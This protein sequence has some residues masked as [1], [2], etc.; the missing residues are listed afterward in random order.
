MHRNHHNVTKFLSDEKTRGAINTNFFKRLDHMN[1]QLYEVELAM[2]EIEHRKPIIVGFFIVQYAKLRMLE[3][4]Y[5]FFERLF[6]VNNFEDI[7][8]D[9]DSLYLA[10]PEKY[11]CNCIQEES[12]GEWELM[13]SED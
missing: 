2:A 5:N 6:D 1:D 9:T 10:L 3:L 4:C 11:L 13:R 8:M 12:K 7:E